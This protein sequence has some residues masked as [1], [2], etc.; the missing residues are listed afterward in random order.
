MTSESYPKHH[1]LH[2][3]VPTQTCSVAPSTSS[4]PPFPFCLPPPSRCE[5][6]K[7]LPS[8]G[9]VEIRGT[10]SLPA[11]RLTPGLS[12]CANCGQSVIRRHVVGCGEASTGPSFACF[13]CAIGSCRVPP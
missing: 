2:K 3:V 10:L 8:A 5:L 9:S 11:I 1:L 7:A 4:F 12:Y 6:V 13:A